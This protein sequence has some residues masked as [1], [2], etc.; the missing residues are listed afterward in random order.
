MQILSYYF[1]I[2]HKVVMDYKQI[3]LKVK[4]HSN[5]H[6]IMA[7]SIFLIPDWMILLSQ[8]LMK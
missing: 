6:C 3:R 5:C 7:N 2:G 4:L 8:S 1:D